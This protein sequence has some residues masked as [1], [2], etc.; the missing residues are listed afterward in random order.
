MRLLNTTTFEL[1]NRSKSGI[2]PEPYA[3]LSHRWLGDEEIKFQELGNYTAELRSGTRPLRLLQV[4]KI[5]GACDIARGKNLKWLW[6]DTCCIDKT[7]QR[8]YAEAINSM[9]GWYRDAKLCITYLSDV[10]VHGGNPTRSSDYFKRMSGDLPSEWFSRGW[11]LQELLAPRNLEFYDMNWNYMG[12]K[13]QLAGVLAEI[14]GIDAQ[15]HSGGK[16]LSEA[17]IAAK[18]SWMS[19]RQT[20]FPEDR[21]YSMI[22][23]F[24]INM[25]LVYGET[26]PRA[27]R[28]LQELLLASPFMDESLFAWK[29]PDDDAG[30]EC[31]VML[32]DWEP[33][34]WGL[35]AGSVDWFKESGDI[36]VP[37]G[38]ASQARSFK[39][40]SEGME[41]PICKQIQEGADIIATEAVSTVFWASIVGIPIGVGGFAALRHML[42]KKAKEDYAFRLNCFRFGVDG[43]AANVEV[44][45]RPVYVDHVGVFHDLWNRRGNIRRAVRIPP[46][47]VKGMRVRCKELGLSSKPITNYKDNGIVFQPKPKY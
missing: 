11:T 36:Q 31:D 35:L 16:D 29:M 47:K 43:K 13:E 8:E 6:M 3:I 38:M 41:A 21:A 17:S 46:L 37:S 12:T 10:R 30:K 40:T 20:T 45:L 5:R 32:A 44:Y 2:H 24:N 7:D 27:F 42:K 1:E 23:I 4:D 14:T 19:K 39:M 33:G 26:G 18:M 15:F 9:F 28:R 34:Q 25:P 22:G